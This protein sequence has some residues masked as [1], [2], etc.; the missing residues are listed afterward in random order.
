[1]KHRKEQ[2]KLPPRISGGKVRVYPTNNPPKLNLTEYNAEL[3]SLARELGWRVFEMHPEIEGYPSYCLY[4]E[5][6]REGAP[7]IY[8]QS[9]IH[10]EEQAGP[11][12]L[13]ETLRTN[14]LGDAGA[15]LF[16][17]LNPKGL[18]E[19]RRKICPE[20][21]GDDPKKIKDP[22]GLGSDI[23]GTGPNLAA[24]YHPEVPKP[25]EF[26]AHANMMNTIL[27][28]RQGRP[29]DVA[30]DFHENQAP[31]L[32]R[33]RIPQKNNT[34]RGRALTGSYMYHEGEN[35]ALAEAIRTSLEGSTG[36]APAK[37][38]DMYAVDRP[39]SINMKTAKVQPNPGAYPPTFETIYGYLPNSW[40]RRNDYAKET[41][42]VETH[43]LVLPLEVRVAA[44]VNVIKA[45]IAH[46]EDTP[47]KAQPRKFMGSQIKKYSPARTGKFFR[48]KF[49]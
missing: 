47:L 37:Y 35:P 13:L 24:C 44:G 3:L 40:L 12:I 6:L 15:V 25:P 5:P 17:T 31:H 7:S 42:T 21:K 41:Y 11:Q 18:A 9:G 2:P 1:M 23:D 36:L 14:A 38:L 34:P 49:R 45:T 30:I 27:D 46:L 8:L 48:S 16:P 19:G 22:K 28:L 33:S 32:S 43:S 26:L 10:G 39:G 29:F 4:R 20:R